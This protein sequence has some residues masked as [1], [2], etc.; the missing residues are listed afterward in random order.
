[1]RAAVNDFLRDLIAATL[2][3]AGT[4]EEYRHLRRIRRYRADQ[5]KLRRRYGIHD[6][7]PLVQNLP[8]TDASEV[9]TPGTQVAL[10]S[11]TSS[12]PKRVLYTARRLRAV[13]NVF[14]GSFLRYFRWLGLRRTSL[15]VFGSLKPDSSLTSMLLAEKRPPS[16]LALLQAPYRVHAHPA[17][18]RVTAQHGT[19]AVR[20]WVLAVSNPGV[21][22]STNPSTLYAF[23]E[24]LR[25]DW[26]KCTELVRQAVR[27]P[28]A[29]DA[30]ARRIVRRLASRGWQQ[31]LERIATSRRYLPIS[32]WAPAVRFYACWTGGYVG[33]FLERLRR[34]LPH[35]S[36]TC[37]DMYSMSTEAIETIPHFHKTGLWFL[38]LAPDTFYEY[39]DI[40]VP[41]SASEILSLRQVRNFGFYEMVVSHPYGLTR[42][43]TGDVFLCDGFDSGVPSLRFIRRRDIGYS[44]TGEKLTATQVQGAIREIQQDEDP[45]TTCVLTCFPSEP[46]GA[47][48]PC[49]RLVAVRMGRTGPT[50]QPEIADQFDE[51]LQ[52]FN[53]EY[54][55]KRESKRLGAVRFE[56]IEFDG[57]RRLV[58]ENGLGRWD[59]QFKFL[60][61]Y[62]RLWE[63]LKE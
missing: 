17:L 39:L 27:D 26:T 20:L 54:K 23:F 32:A 63:S 28:Q 62:P 4:F 1:M 16:L 33:P 31:R 60:S 45:A 2:Q 40:D 30:E 35:P 9:A 48:L 24:E 38:P 6:D 50:P 25:S 15:Y 53:L 55:S 34:H 8:T 41:E 19:V 58:E 47:S 11:G 29:L 14:I 43:R 59:S 36:F 13:R 5:R 10:T 51:L 7:T 46:P 61:I 22:Y 37:V 44:F 42:Y 57:F 52:E 49:Y 18:R 56:T 21:L 3:C 12:D